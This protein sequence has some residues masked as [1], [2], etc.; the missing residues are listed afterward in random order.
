M[1]EQRDVII[2]PRKESYCFTFSK[3]DCYKLA[4]GRCTFELTEEE[5]EEEKAKCNYRYHHAS[6]VGY[7]RELLEKMS[8][9]GTMSATTSTG[10][11]GF[12]NSCG[13]IA[14]LNGQHRTCI[15]KKNNLS[16]LYFDR[17]GDSRENLCRSCYFENKKTKKQRSFWSIF[18]I[19][20]KVIDNEDILIY[21]TDDKL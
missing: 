14:F 1:T 4:T 19:K 5:Y 15:A 2:D 18:K 9:G 20:K 13:H 7:C 16:K 12:R 6:R 11:N 3:R 10:I 21:I 17:L 8:D